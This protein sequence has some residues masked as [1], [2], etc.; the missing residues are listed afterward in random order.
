MNKYSL[1]GWSVVDEL[2]G[3]KEAIG[4]QGIYI[5]QVGD[6]KRGSIER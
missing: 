2:F 4:H 3:R 5:I 6:A 1:V